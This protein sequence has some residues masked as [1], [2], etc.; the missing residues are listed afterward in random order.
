[1]KVLII[2][3]VMC[4][5]SSII[6]QGISLRDTTNQYDYII[7]TIPEFVS[8]CEPFQQH[9][10]MVR[11]YN[12]LIV[13][14]NQIYAEFDS[15]AAGENNIRNFLSY[16]ISFWQNP[17]PVFALIAGSVQFIPNRLTAEYMFSILISKI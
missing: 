11:N 13:S 12:T 10:E 3:L 8:T 1:M 4:I 15:S 17:K 9:K 7:I 16:A 2:L 6:P 14:T 5:T